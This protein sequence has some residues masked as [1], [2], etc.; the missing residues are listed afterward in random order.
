MKVKSVSPIPLG[1]WTTRGSR[2]R[3]NSSCRGQR[4]RMRPGQR[5]VCSQGPCE[6]P[7][8]SGCVTRGSMGTME[9]PYLFRN[10]LSPGARALCLSTLSHSHSLKLRGCARHLSGMHGAAAAPARAAARSLPA[11]F[12]LQAPTQHLPCCQGAVPVPPKDKSLTQETSLQ[13]AEG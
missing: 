5:W 12:Q 6:T 8:T 11:S 4:K 7:P 9:P 1:S 2:S 10:L 3:L 13:G